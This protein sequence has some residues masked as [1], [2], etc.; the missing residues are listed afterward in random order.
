M[1]RVTNAGFTKEFVGRAILPDWWDDHCSEDPDLLQDLEIR[2]ARFLGYSVAS[3]ADP[4]A[5]LV[6]P[7]YPAA[8]LRRVRDINRD[9]LRPA[10][11]TAIRIA[12]AVARSLHDTA[13]RTARMPSL[14]ADG[15]AWRREIIRDTVALNLID[16]ATDLWERGIPIVPLD[17]LPA[18]YFQG[19]ACIVE[20]R[21][22]ILLGYKHDEPGRVAFLI[23]HEAGHIAA[24]DCAPEQPV[25][26][27]EEE[28]A[29]DTDIERLADL[30]ATKVLVGSINVPQ[31]E[32]IEARDFKELARQASATERTAGADASSMIF[33][34][35]RRT[36]DYATATMA[37][38][39]LYRNTGAR[40]ILRRLFASRVDLAG[41]TE[42]DRDLLRCVVPDEVAR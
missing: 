34:W 8:Q 31:L 20:D 29:D 27:E 40:K 19:M 38:Q 41:A 21:P 2:I 28:I 39:A 14:P 36:G 17:I 37:V 5:P 3:I 10:I 15:L 42:T 13:L 23:A 4:N 24:G 32:N 12:A 9:R 18:P 11:H 33:A 35:A 6:P 7:L 1:R 16:I 26:D 25:V 22:V 30:Y